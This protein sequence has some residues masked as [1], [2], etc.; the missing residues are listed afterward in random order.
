MIGKVHKAAKKSMK[1]IKDDGMI[2]FGKR[3]TKYAY[4]RKFPSEN[5]S[6][7]KIFFLLMVAPCRIPSATAWHTKWNS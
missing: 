6:I 3:A 4:Y 7:T 5:R 2:G 1:I